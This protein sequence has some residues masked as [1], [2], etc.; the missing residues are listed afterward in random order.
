[1]SVD[2]VRRSLVWPA[3]MAACSL[4]LSASPAVAGAA[5]PARPT[6]S[7]KAATPSPA[8]KVEGA[9]V[10]AT[11]KG[12]S[13]TGGFMT[14]RASRDL[15]LVGFSSDAATDTELHE[16][17]MD[18]SVMRM[19]AVERLPLPAG[20]AVVLKPGGHH[21]MLMGLK[22]PLA[23]GSEVQVELHLEDA[24]GAHVQQAITLPVRAGHGGAGMQGGESA[25]QPKGP[26]G[27]HHHHH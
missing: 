11:V 14:L 22:Q 19:R 23:A 20:K 21:L 3:V 13:A 18:G 10:R 17:A 27:G 8:V 7:A 5:T 16:M 12:Q 1:M 26:G 25:A 4:V 15:T 24:S 6:S 9:W 2:L